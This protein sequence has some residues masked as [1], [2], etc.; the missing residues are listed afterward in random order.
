MI[1]ILFYLDALSQRSVI[2]RRSQASDPVRLRLSNTK[3][4]QLCPSMYFFSGIVGAMRCFLWDGWERRCFIRDMLIHGDS[5]AAVVI[6]VSPLLVASYC[7]DL[8]GVCVLRFPDELAME[9]TLSCGDHLLTV[10]NSYSLRMP[11]R[12]R[13]IAPDLM[14]GFAANPRYINFWPLIAEFL[15]DDLERIDI[16]KQRIAKEEFAH[17]QALG[18]EL[19]R[20]FGGAARNGR[21]D[22][23]MRPARVSR[24]K[25]G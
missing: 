23:S 15:S 7:D 11:A 14:Q 6:S 20:R 21:P 18:E 1:G 8:D 9:H 3:L 10:L 16:R 22:R 5:R 19:L 24:L 13:Q 12:P 2:N 17:C 4:R 25:P